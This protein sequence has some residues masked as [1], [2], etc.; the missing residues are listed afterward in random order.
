[1]KFRT[2]C[3]VAVAAAFALP[4]CK[5]PYKESDKK[6]EEKKK[7]M[8]GDHSFQAVLG[9]LRIAA[10][11]QDFQELAQLMT[12]DFGYRWDAA[13]PGETVFSYW[14]ANNVWPELNRVLEQNFVPHEDFMVAPAEFAADS[15]N[16]AGYR[17]GM[18]QINGAWKFAYFVGAPPAGEQATGQ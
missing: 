5:T 6:R 3:I 11:K 4:A 14:Q 8:S 15:V 9:R 16:Y 7:D 12:S 10:K 2:L 1:M 18:K 17:A 13:P